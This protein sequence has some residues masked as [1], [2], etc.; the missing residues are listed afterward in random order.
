MGLGF[1]I[2]QVMSY[3]IFSKLLG[4]F[5]QGVLMGFLTAAGSLAR[6]IGPIFVSYIYTH[7]GPQI[8]FAILDGYIG[9]VI[10]LA[11]LFYTRLVPYKYS[12]G[13][14]SKA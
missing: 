4:P 2:A 9:V 1:P 12:R 5:P 13:L 11:V 7:L 14:S 8:T 6:S 10:I 3:T